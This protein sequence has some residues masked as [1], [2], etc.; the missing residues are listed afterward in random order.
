MLKSFAAIALAAI[1][2]TWTPALLAQPAKPA[3][4][5]VRADLEYAVHDGVKLTGTLYGPRGTDKRPVIVAIHGGGW[6]AGSPAGYQFWGPYLAARGYALFAIRYRLATPNQPMYPQAVYD[7]RAAIQFVR[8]RAADL[9]ADGERIALMGD[10]AGG[11]LA[12]LVALAG[13]SYDSLYRDDPHAK[14]SVRV[15]AVIPVYGVYDMVAQWNHDQLH[16]P[17]DQISQTFLGTTPARDRRRFIDA[18]PISY[19]TI[20]D[21]APSFLLG[22]GTEDDIVEPKTQAEPFLVALKQ[23]R[24]F[25][26]TVIVTGAP[27]FWNSDPIEEPESHAG[28]LA[29]RLLRLLAQRL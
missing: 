26:R 5:Q 8:A 2:L 13:E 1:A 3:D 22:W 7:V 14:V 18:S 15:K 19:A 29:P 23:A 9:G 4:V 11:H 25:V 24:F 20:R 21:D 12:A 16:R 28:F 6:Q 10:S 27:H 17:T